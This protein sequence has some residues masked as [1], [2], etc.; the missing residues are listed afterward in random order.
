MY[1]HKSGRKGGSD[2]AE[3]GVR[4]PSVWT[5]D[6][7]RP[8]ANT[9]GFTMESLRTFFLFQPTLP[10]VQDT[11]APGLQCLRRQKRAAGE[12]GK[13]AVTTGIGLVA[14]DSG[15]DLDVIRLKEGRTGSRFFQSFMILTFLTRLRDGEIAPK[16]DHNDELESFFYGFCYF[17]ATHY[18]WDAAR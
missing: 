12:A 15:K 2:V 17:P 4:D 18:Q 8:F 10:T 5:A 16:H 11:T 13:D 9:P 6:G 7:H 14:P 3:E 1:R